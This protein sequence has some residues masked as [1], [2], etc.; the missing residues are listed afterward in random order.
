MYS[1][2]RHHTYILLYYTLYKH[3]YMGHIIVCRSHG[4]IPG[5]Q[6]L[7]LQHPLVVFLVTIVLARHRDGGSSRNTVVAYTATLSMLAEK[8]KKKEIL[9]VR[10]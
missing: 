1:T 8:E 10:V 5:G 4:G 3:S 6:Y 7:R 2:T 9:S